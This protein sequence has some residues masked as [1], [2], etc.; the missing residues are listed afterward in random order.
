MAPN[1][2]EAAELHRAFSRWALRVRARRL[3]R[4]V[5]SGVALGLLIGGGLAAVLWWQRQGQLRPWSAALGLVGGLGGLVVGLIRRW[6]DVD[7]AL[8][9]DARLA[10]DEAICTAVSLDPRDE[11]ASPARSVVLRRASRSLASADPRRARPPLLSFWQAA[12]PVG[13]GAVIWLSLLPLPA[14]PPEAVPPPG[15]DTVSIANLAGLE[16][17]IALEQLDPRD[18]EQRERLRRIAE[19]AR[20]LRADVARGIP[21]REALARIARLRDDIAAQRLRFGDES[22]RPG[23]EAAIRKLQAIPQTGA[24][25][26]AL[27][28]GD[29]TEFDEEMRRLAALAEADDRA[30]AKQVLE[31]AEKAA[32]ERGARG[33]ADELRQQSRAFDERQAQADALRDLAESLGKGLSEE[34]RRDLEEFGETGSPEAQKRLAEALREALEGLTD[35]ERK[36]LSERLQLQLDGDGDVNPLTRDKLE[37][38][39]RRLSTPEGRKELSET[40]KELTRREPT[41]EARREQG[42]DDAERGGAQS[43]RQLGGA[44]PI[45]VETEG[46]GA[47]NRHPQGTPKSG[48]DEGRDRAGGGQ[49]GP[50][51]E[52]GEHEGKT[53]AVP[54]DALRAKASPRFDPRAPMHGSSLGRAPARAGET[55]NQQGTGA[56]GRVAPDEVSGVQRSEVPREYREQ[57]GRYFQ[58]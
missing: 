45:P 33:L 13:L 29:L 21:R 43:Q 49:N 31:E 23:L 27:G 26:E 8:Y 54:G 3:T 19:E 55:A 4:R 28:N 2:A 44:M 50:D 30:A 35:E 6:S 42:L 5:L 58:P 17:I 46:R 56:L 34:A 1:H 14:P 53:D 39:S 7:V 12:A 37:E 10:A 24:A 47:P 48:T 36:R 32:R 16:S 25:A 18:A 38:L 40:L 41:P 15:A 22:N 9:L 51:T 20:R 11:A 52:P 57:V